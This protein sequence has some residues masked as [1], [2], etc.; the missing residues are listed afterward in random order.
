MIA[1]IFTKAVDEETFHWCKHQLRNTSRESYATRKIAKLR[2][3]LGRA[4]D[5]RSKQ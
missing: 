5:G 2:A 3:A 4:L 1:D